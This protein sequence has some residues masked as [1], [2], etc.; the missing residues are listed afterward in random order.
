MVDRAKKQVRL[1]WTYNQPEVTGYSIYKTRADG[2]PR[3]YKQQD[4]TELMTRSVR[5]MR[6]YI[7][8]VQAVFSTGEKSMFSKKIKIEF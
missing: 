8:Y 7:I 6:A 5:L 2:V 3:L 1:S 4:G